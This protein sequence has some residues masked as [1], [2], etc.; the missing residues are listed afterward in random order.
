VTDDEIL[1]QQ[2]GN[3]L[4]KKFEELLGH[5]KGADLR[6]PDAEGKRGETGWTEDIENVLRVLLFLYRSGKV[7]ELTNLPQRF[8]KAL[9]LQ[10]TV[11]QPIGT[12]L[13]DEQY[14]RWRARL[15]S[16]V[17]QIDNPI[18]SKLS[19]TMPLEYFIYYWSAL[20]LPKTDR[21]SLSK[22]IEHYNG[23]GAQNYFIVPLGA[24]AQEKPETY[25]EYLRGLSQRLYQR[26]EYYDIVQIDTNTIYDYRSKGAI[27]PFNVLYQLNTRELGPHLRIGQTNDSELDALPASRNFHLPAWHQS[28]KWRTGEGEEQA[29]KKTIKSVRAFL[30]LEAGNSGGN[31]ADLK[32]CDVLSELK[33]LLGAPQ[34]LTQ[35]VSQY[36]KG[37]SVEIA[38]SP[39]DAFSWAAEEN[40]SA[41]PIVT[42][43]LLVPGDVAPFVP[44]QLARGAHAAYTFMA[45]TANTPT[46]GQDNTESFVSIGGADK[47]F[48]N[49]GEQEPHKPILKVLKRTTLETRLTDVLNMMFNFVPDAALCCDHL[50]SAAIRDDVDLKS[51]W[52]DP[53]LPIEAIR[54]HKKSPEIFVNVTPTNA[55]ANALLTC[56]GGFCWGI[57]AAAHDAKSAASVAWNLVVSQAKEAME[58]R[59]NT[60]LPNSVLLAPTD[61]MIPLEDLKKLRDDDAEIAKAI[62]ETETRRRLIPTPK[63]GAVRPNCAVWP[64]IEDEIS[65]AFRLY[66][67]A[68][69]VFRALHFEMY[70]M[71]EIG[72]ANFVNTRLCKRAFA[73]HGQ[74]PEAAAAAWFVAAEGQAASHK[75]AE[76]LCV[77]AL[78]SDDIKNY[79]SNISSCL[80]AHPLCSA[81]D[82]RFGPLDEIIRNNIEPLKADA[83]Y[84]VGIL[85]DCADKVEAVN[86]TMLRLD[87]I[88]SNNP[89]AAQNTR[90]QAHFEQ[91]RTKI[92]ESLARSL[93]ETVVTKI[94]SHCES[95]GWKPEFV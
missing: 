92:I 78:H 36:W 4:K 95:S 91:I 89:G 2:R 14:L 82:P 68:L 5:K 39:Y 70:C 50:L 45:Y 30:A 41:R 94:A 38:R 64:Q 26:H 12:V 6:I 23:P 51:L 48:A 40:G 8:L 52:F 67:A 75:S 90:H 27:T 60:P 3:D 17:D 11:P 74:P 21:A 19:N 77:D 55:G 34:S 44:M 80:S 13:G 63:S 81:K 76:L 47:K 59:E 85:R 49:G 31:L 24:N 10:Y 25:D 88:K 83:D 87:D 62:K 1:E 35:F 46:L 9:F 58:S 72:F 37:A 42:P 79:L 18:Y 69:F 16:I 33:K 54:F 93:A 43:F 84:V 73:K 61:R 22:I 53:C 29:A 15:L 57:S 66:S 71:N 65:D 86:I 28:F 56:F 32:N 20:D 7:P